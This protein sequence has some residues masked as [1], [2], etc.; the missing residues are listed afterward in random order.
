M[1][2][3][4]A[5]RWRGLHL[6]V[7]SVSVAAAAALWLLPRPGLERRP[8]VALSM[9]VLAGALGLR[10]VHFPALRAEITASHPFVFASLVACGP[11]SAAL[12]D[13]AA[14]LTAMWAA[15]ARVRALRALF[16]LAAV[17][18][19]TAG[20]WVVFRALG[21]V[22]GGPP[23]AQIAPLAGATAGYFL[24]NTWLVAVA[25][26]LER[27]QRLRETWSRSFRWTAA[28]YFSGLTLAVVLLLLL[29][30]FGLAAVLLGV[31]PC[32][33]LLAFYR[34]YRARLEE[35]RRRIEAVEALNAE[36]EIK[37]A[38]RTQ[39]L[40]QALAG[41]EEANQRLRET[42]RRLVEANRA[43]NEFLASVSHELRTP[44]NAILGFSELLADG[45]GGSL[46]P[47]QRDYLTEIRESGEHLLE[48]INDILDLSKI[49]AGKMRVQR[50]ATDVAALVRDV[51]SM[52][53]P[54]ADKKGLALEV[55]LD[56]TPCWAAVD[57]GMLRQV[58]VNL[59]SNAVK[60][61]PEGGRVT[62]GARF[63]G[64]SLCVEVRDTGIGIA[65]EEQERIFEA[66]YQVDGSYSRQHQGTGLGL[67][68]VKRMMEL[69]GGTVEVR[70][71]PQQGAAFTC[72]FPQARAE[73]APGAARA[74][75]VPAAK[76]GRSGS[77][78][79][80]VLVADGHALS[81]KL[82]RNALR[83]RGH[84]VCEAADAETALALVE[85][86]RPDLVLLDAGLPPHG[87][88][89]CAAR[90]RETRPGAGV[91]VLLLTPP[92]SGLTFAEA[93]AAGCCG[94]VGKPV[95][96]ARLPGLVEAHVRGEGCGG[97][98]GGEEDVA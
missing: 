46:N 75:G 47:Q 9:A 90:L 3:R 23:A 14:V 48:L 84:E 18:V 27:G 24:C 68:L 67:A 29:D 70:S 17:V 52:M 45:R 22:V 40:R 35:Q 31:P 95:R 78:P 32:W 83:S 55:S 2:L 38:A 13:L 81:R 39:E 21:G 57:R 77:A 49:E 93:R 63:E 44:L 59:A 88:T 92:G 91:H 54:L 6:W 69:H 51:A 73:N 66:F 25:I 80:A 7:A 12:A 62:L 79:A 89:A 34:T 64:D 85:A 1:R 97:L 11:F 19:S 50:E 61:T 10:P 74:E 20:A 87:G 96:L 37:V 30:R 36:L 94:L 26:A 8:L 86:R 56:A 16:N 72:R 65:C 43:K 15:R 41:L 53:R 71:R 98:R 4:E 33:L 28:A 5:R 58:L 60:F 76:G 42:N 82:L